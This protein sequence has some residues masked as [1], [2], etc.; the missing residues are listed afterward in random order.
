MSTPGLAEN[1]LFLQPLLEARIADQVGQNIPV[2][3]IEEL[4]Q[5]GAEDKRPYVIFVYWAGDR[6]NEGDG[7]RAMSGSAQMMAQRW[8]VVLY[9]NNAQHANR[10]ARNEAAGAMLSQLHK[11]LAG[12]S[13]L[14]PQ[15]GSQQKFSRINGLRPDYTK[16]SGL[17]PLMFEIPLHL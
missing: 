8:L 3:G 5:A 16:T 6:F 2:E 15:P 13:P 1:Y 4:A 7:G 17:Y 14:G 9:V 12:W 10:K 11:A